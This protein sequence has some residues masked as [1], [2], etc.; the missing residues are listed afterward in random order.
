MLLW[1]GH[2]SL[3]HLQPW[4]SSVIAPKHLCSVG[5]FTHMLPETLDLGSCALVNADSLEKG[6][7]R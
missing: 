5:A 4:A 7:E 1:Q 2:Y 3:G 6:L